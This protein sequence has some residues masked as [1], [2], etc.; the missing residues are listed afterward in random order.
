MTRSTTLGGPENPDIGGSKALLFSAFAGIAVILVFAVTIALVTQNRLSTAVQ[1]TTTEA[2]P[3]LLAALRLSGIN[4]LLAATTPT[5]STAND[6]SELDATSL[7]L[8]VLLAD[9]ESQLGLLNGQDHEGTTNKARQAVQT[10]RSTLAKL[11]AAN[12]Q[13]IH[14][15]ARQKEAWLRIQSVHSKLIDTVSPVVYGVGSLNQLFARRALRRQNAG[16]RKLRDVLHPRVL[17]LLELDHLVS[18]ASPS[19]ES[20]KAIQDRLASLRGTLSE[21]DFESLSQAVKPFLSSEDSFSGRLESYRQ[22]LAPKIDRAIGELNQGFRDLTEQLSLATPELVE[23]T[24]RDLSVAIDIKAE[25]NLLLALLSAV[26]DVDQIDA[27][28]ELEGQFEK[29]AA[30]FQSAAEAF[31]GSPLAQRNPIL[32]GNVRQL[33][34]HVVDFDRGTEDP[35]A[36]RRKQLVLRE[37]IQHLLATHREVAAQL[38]EH[39]RETVALRR[40]DTDGMARQM[41]VTRRTSQW[42]L[43][44]VSVGGLLLMALIA[45]TTIRMLERREQQ[46]Q[47]AQRAA[48]S[49][50][51][52][53]DAIG[54][55]ARAL[56][57]SEYWEQAIETVLARL[58]EAIGASRVMLY[59]NR[60]AEDNQWH[61]HL[62]HQWRASD[63][64][65]SRQEATPEVI[66]YRESGLSRWAK[67]LGR[68]ELLCGVASNFPV[69]ERALLESH[70]IRSLLMVPI[71]IN[72]EFWGHISI[73]D[74]ERDRTWLPKEQ[75]ILV[76]AADTLGTAMARDL[77]AQSLRQAAIVF[78][79]TPEGVLVTDSEGTIVA[80]NPAFAEISGYAAEELIGK[81]PR[82]FKS[83]LQ[84]ADLAQEMWAGLIETGHWEGEVSNRRKD[85]SVYTEWLT[86]HSVRDN[87]G[88]LSHYVAVFAHVAAIKEAQARMYHLAHHDP[89]TDLPNRLLLGDRLAHAIERARRDHHRVAVLFLDLDRFKIINDT[90]GH[91]V[92]DAILRH[93][94]VRLQRH[95][96]AED[97]VA[98]LGGDE[99][100]VVIDHLKHPEEA[101]FI[102]QKVIEALTEEM[103][104]DDLKFYLTGSIGISLFP[105]DGESTDELIKNADTAMYRAKERGRNQY[106]YYTSELTAD[107][108][109][110]FALTNNLRLALERDEFELYYQPQRELSSRR[111]IGVEALLRWHHP[112]HGL[113]RPDRFIPVAEDAGLMV[114]IGTWVL[115]T[116]CRQARQWADAGLPPFKMAINLSGK[117]LTR[118]DLPEIIGQAL[119]DSDLTPG[120]LE[121]EITETFVMHQPEHTIGVLDRLRG[122]GVSLAIDDFGTGHSSLSQLKRLPSHCLKIDRSFVRDLPTDPNDE[123]I[124]RAIVAM[125]HALGLG[126]IAEGIENSQQAE[127]LRQAGCD[128]GQGYHFGYPVPANEMYALLAAELR[129]LSAGETLKSA[130]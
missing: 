8:D 118:D 56:L 71:Q 34:Q 77:A 95:M 36:L 37:H 51:R 128:V 113:I 70:G 130:G 78:D 93:V 59:Q 69:Q 15:A 123:A 42:V 90:L 17:A 82:I 33:A 91:G 75:E 111:L 115:E 26:A 84:P 48:L 102:A 119:R 24:T 117:Q 21:D 39:T 47:G 66:H 32:A 125:G 79:S 124:A 129:Q 1:R 127:V 80:A 35:F 55:S 92:G 72:E 63:A 43:I 108:M 101:G 5:L 60:R 54:Y 83:N 104:V 57:G 41:E 94:G 16:V 22:L 126:I 31:Q 58:G 100:M 122:M 106:H 38:T 28:G 81:N 18:G 13:R 14:L 2:L 40:N 73:E 10:M 46:L 114:P 19:H 64:S 23:A 6:R 25:G 97:T 89:L 85:G 50:N 67:C 49:A 107:A 99:F 86:I 11:K 30:T 103:R 29:S 116:A 45:F 52:I 61:A 112:E 62:V 105:D 76:A 110:H 53:L 27:L 120:H 44:A 87:A 98:R 9:V 68:G 20:A 7:R 88:N 65:N 121:L 96:R 74:C 3:E 109:E 12:Y 4:A